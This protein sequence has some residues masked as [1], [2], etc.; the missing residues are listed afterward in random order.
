MSSVTVDDVWDLEAESGWLVD[1]RGRLRSLA[2]TLTD[3]ATTVGTTRTD[4]AEHWEGARAESYLGY[5]PRLKSA[6]DD[7]GTEAGAVERV[8]QQIDDDLD[9]AQNDLDSSY[10]RASGA[11]SSAS[12]SGG[13]VTFTWP[14]D[15]D[16]PDEIGTQQGRAQTVLSGLRDTLRARATS[17]DAIAQRALT[18]ADAWA[19]PAEGTP[20]WDYP[21]DISYGVM[22]TTLGNT[23]TVTTGDLG[24]SIEVTVDPETGETVLRITHITETD[25]RVEEIRIPAG[26]EVVINTGG[27][28]DTITVPAGTDV[29][30]RF[31][32]GEGEDTVSAQEAEGDIEAFGGEGADTIELG[33]G[34]DTVHGGADDDYIDTGDGDDRVFGGLGNDILYGM[35][36]DDV[37]SGGEGNDYLEGARGD[38]T[39][40][41]GDGD[42]IVS[43]GFGDD[44]GHGGRGDD[45][46]YAGSGTDSFTGGQGTD[47]VTGEDH[48]TLDGEQRI[49]IE[50]PSE[51]HYTRWLEFEVDGSDAF[52]ERILADLQ[53]MASS[54]TGQEMLEAQGRHYDESGFLGIGKDKVTIREFDEQ[55]GYASPDGYIV[56]INPDYQGSINNSTDPNGWTGKPPVV[57]LFHELGH[58][59]QFR[60]QGGG[61]GHWWDPDATA[62][63]GTQGDWIRDENGQPLIE[64]QNVG[65]PWDTDVVP[66]GNGEDYEFDLTENGFRDELGVPRRE[67]Y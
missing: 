61:S 20:D 11:C 15:E 7:A 24:D 55:N 46:L 4:L 21:K 13:S 32:G 31:S 54:E 37:V 29:D 19:G 62:P 38:D 39:L 30:L 3:Q 56:T 26:R 18:I 63:D 52:K 45:T 23:T 16:Q 66:E 22:Q 1:A 58:I 28:S 10:V 35:G 48:D 49:T 41:A 36:G 40:F 25:C 27:G 9:G 14:D 42:D 12:R 57:V 51:E 34:S 47:K 50:I 53:M 5:A 60:S 59:N 8:L 2:T 43:G 33:S 44:T 6:L 65:L 64:R 67:W 17:L